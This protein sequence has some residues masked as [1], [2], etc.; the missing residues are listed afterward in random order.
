MDMSDL[1]TVLY[2][3]TITENAVF[4]FIKIDSLLATKFSV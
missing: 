2:Y 4:L 3:K 1:Y